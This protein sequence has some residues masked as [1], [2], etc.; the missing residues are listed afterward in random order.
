MGDEF[1]DKI[2]KSKTMY[3][4]ALEVLQHKP[5]KDLEKILKDIST[6]AT[7]EQRISLL[8][9]GIHFALRVTQEYNPRYLSIDKD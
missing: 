9:F 2:M 6:I 7:R 8:R 5:S 1:S 3:R 4:V